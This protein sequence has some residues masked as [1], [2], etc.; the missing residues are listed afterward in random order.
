MNKSL[1]ERLTKQHTVL[2]TVSSC[3]LILVFVCRSLLF[4]RGQLLNWQFAWM[5]EGH[6]EREMSWQTAILDID[7]QSG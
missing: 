1:L 2:G 7:N 3:F 4:F 6:V 5:Q